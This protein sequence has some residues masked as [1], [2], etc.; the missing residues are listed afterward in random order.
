MIAE[1]FK[2]YPD[3]RVENRCRYVI[4]DLLSIALLTYCCGGMEYTDMSEFAATRARLFG[5]LG[6]CE[7][8]VFPSPDTFERL[9][10]ALKPA[11]LEKCLL[12]CGRGV[13][14][15][16]K[17]K[18]IAIDGKKQRGAN[19]KAA[20]TAGEYILNAFVCENCISIGQEALRDKD[21]EIKVLPA[22]LEKLE[23]KG[24]TVSIDAVGTQVAI[25]GMITGC[26]GNYLLAVK[27][28]Q[29]T[30][31]EEIRLAFS[32]SQP[33][34]T[35]EELDC[36]HGRIEQRTCRILPADRIS[37]PDTLSRWPGLKTIVEVTNTTTRDGATTTV[38]RHFISSE[39]ST[40]A[41]HYGKMVRNHWA[42]ENNL[43]WHLDVNFHEDR[44]RTRSGFAPQN[45]SILRKMS[46]QIMKSASDKKSIRKRLFR[47]ALDPDYLIGLLL[48]Y[49]F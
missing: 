21:N 42:I 36:G 43:H 44:C 18:Q 24:T 23:L 6:N 7:D 3:H 1:I 30:L 49:K 10:K 15:E 8:G 48:N 35:H 26:G 38:T 41:A 17:N 9:M 13:I 2:D 45:L 27:D 31:H 16:L 22:I 40:E 12:A 47:S 29:K 34:S 39:D 20:R 14:D 11:E 25:A 28:N 19:P 32:V 37:D 46:L 5:L 4:A 33:V